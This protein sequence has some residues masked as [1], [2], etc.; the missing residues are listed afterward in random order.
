MFLGMISGTQQVLAQVRTLDPN[1]NKTQLINGIPLVQISAPNA[2]GASTTFY[3]SHNV[4]KHGM[5]YNN[6]TTKQGV[7]NSAL[8]GTVGPNPNLTSNAAGLII[9]QVVSTRES[10]LAGMTEVV[11]QAA[12]VMV[13]NPNGITCRGCG[14]INT[15][16]VT[17]TTGR[18]EFAANGAVSHINVQG[19]NV[20]FS[21]AGYAS[22]ST[23]NS[24]GGDMLSLGSA[25]SASS[26]SQ[27]ELAVG[28]KAKT[29][30]SASASSRYEKTALVSRFQAGGNIE[31][32]TSGST[33]LDATKM[34]AGDTINI[35]AGSL[36]FK[37]AE[38]AVEQDRT[39]NKGELDLRAKYTNK[40]WGGEVKGGYEHDA[41]RKQEHSAVVGSLSAG[42]GAITIATTSDAVLTGVNIAA[43]KDVTITSR[44]G[45]VE[46]A[47][48]KSTTTETSAGANAALKAKVDPNFFLESSAGG[49]YWKDS[50]DKNTVTQ[51]SARNGNVETMAGK[52]LTLEGAR[53]T[54]SENATL[55][56]GGSV[57]LLEARDS[58][59]LDTVSVQGA[60][61]LSQSTDGVG[62]GLAV[63]ILRKDRQSGQVSEVVAGKTLTIAA[64]AH[65]QV[66]SQ[67]AKRVA[68]NE[69]LQGERRD[70]N[71]TEVNTEFYLPLDLGVSKRD[72]APK[73][74]KKEDTYVMGMGGVTTA[75][76]GV[77]N[78]TFFPLTES[79]ESKAV[80]KDAY[81]Y[82]A[83]VESA[84][85]AGR[86]VPER[87]APPAGTAPIQITVPALKNVD[88]ARIKTEGGTSLPGWI[89]FDK[90]SGALSGS[91]PAGFTGSIAI[92]VPDPEGGAASVV[93]IGK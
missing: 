6:V 4:D 41:G 36:T 2:A 34:V 28:G 38:N 80:R 82:Q 14:F 44:R 21:G 16:R 64:G 83:A 27:N 47:A 13:V 92:V 60:V 81:D 11:G 57:M 24:A 7:A 65:G 46:L 76:N 91:R 54:A 87:S 20:L 1:K 90:K 55:V 73:T 5:A 71:K 61:N 62:L 85:R 22:T 30:T 45:N 89:D 53:V 8:L 79:A 70:I 88:R 50:E 72:G 40:A 10:D 63:N 23:I 58:R 37:A 69:T 67:E 52:N 42:A 78:L 29:T 35:Q 19:G 18:P 39:L 9:S 86:T 77:K 68:A 43:E 15:P 84:L 49:A 31:S 12:D 51:I 56:A 33:V 17:L 93:E 25:P 32:T 48:A 75:E 66:L 3:T 26:F 74:T 59:K